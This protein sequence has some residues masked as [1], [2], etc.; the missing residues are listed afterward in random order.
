MSYID[1]L[2]ETEINELVENYINAD[3]LGDYEIDALENDSLFMRRVLMRSND[4]NMYYLCS[5]EL[6][7]NKEF[8]KF[9]IRRFNNDKSFID[10]V[11][12][13]YYALANEQQKL[14]Y[15]ALQ[16][17]MENI[18][19]ID[20]LIDAFDYFWDNSKVNSEKL[21][22]AIK[23][24]KHTENIPR[25]VILANTMILS[26]I[27][28][29]S[30]AVSLVKDE[31]SKTLSG[32]GFCCSMDTYEGNEIILN[33]IARAYLN[34]IIYDG[35]LT[36]EEVIH[37]SFT[38]KEALNSYGISAFVVDYIKSKDSFLAEYVA[39][40][41]ELLKPYIK[42]FKDAYENWDNYNYKLDKKRIEF[43][44]EK[45]DDY[46]YN[47]NKKNEIRFPAMDAAYYVAKKLGLHQK[48][49][50]Y[51]LLTY[52]KNREEFYDSEA[53][54]IE[55]Y[56]GKFTFAELNYF[57]Y[58]EKL[59][60]DLF[61]RRYLNEEIYEKHEEYYDAKPVDIVDFPDEGRKS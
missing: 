19:D 12:M 28:E 51:N 34:S 42:E 10:D 13:N 44:Y 30:I 14:D 5:D 24:S 53:S 57:N 60:T 3:D 38:S 27:I 6:K 31:E 39:L 48:F 1:C 45:A 47:Y 20:N 56:Q 17:F 32:L 36:V 46:I 22:L 49:D 41:G 2:N 18:S 29:N 55:I 4:K 23:L 26:E 40:R 11:I 43:I 35:K 37:S 59:I 54:I 21:E 7:V 61:S 15:E 25:G 16:L 50:E 33:A 58:L 9:L 52:Y 8:L